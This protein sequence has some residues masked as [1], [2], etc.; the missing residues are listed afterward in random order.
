MQRA[1]AFIWGGGAGCLILLAVSTTRSPS[2]PQVTPGSRLEARVG[3]PPGVAAVLRKAC[4]DCHSSE[5][6][7]PWYGRIPPGRWLV[8]RDVAQ[9]RRAMS[10]SEWPDPRSRGNTATGLLMAACA[11]VRARRMPP[12]RYLMLHPEARLTPAEVES[13]CG[14]A[15]TQ[16][17]R[18]ASLRR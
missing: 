13:L 11:V 18:I 15:R 3:V 8:A 14:W 6:R 5:T 9:A 7:W 1:H 10:F 16:A 17:A 12:E 4:Y 2:N